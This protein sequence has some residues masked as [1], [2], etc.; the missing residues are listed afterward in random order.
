MSK[1]IDPTD[2]QVIGPYN[3][4]WRF[5]K[6]G[7]H[8]RVHDPRGDLFRDEGSGVDRVPP[9]PE[10]VWGGKWCRVASFKWASGDHQVH[11]ESRSATWTLNHLAR[12]PSCHGKR[13]LIL[14]DAMTVIL[15]RAKGRGGSLGLCRALRRST[16]LVL[17][18][19]LRPAWR[20][21]PSEGDAADPASRGRR[22]LSAAAWRPL[23]Y[24]RN[25][26]APPRN[27]GAPSGGRFPLGE[28]LLET[29]DDLIR[30]CPADDGLGDL[31]DDLR[32]HGP[33]P[34]SRRPTAA[35]AAAPDRP[36]PAAAGAGGREGRNYRN[37][38]QRDGGHRCL[39]ALLE[40]SPSDPKPHAENEASSF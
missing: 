32:F 28:G 5:P 33:R 4:R 21:L 19:N 36:R 25:G 24:R 40:M 16:A 27:G 30:G 26:D 6:S 31:A 13:H 34:R 39:P 29:A 38:G 7:E 35:P 22:G 8:D 10:R 23:A 18:A 9:V 1:T 37:G 2:V 20:W 14:G 11:L 3:D 12:A 17:A 15:S